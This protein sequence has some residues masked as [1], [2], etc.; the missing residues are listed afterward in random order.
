MRKVLMKKKIPYP[1][2]RVEW[3]DAV[4]NSC[5]FSVKE[6]E[7]WAKDMSICWCENIGWLVK[8]TKHYIVVA[9][10]STQLSSDTEAQ[11][12]NLQ[13]IPRT[14]CKITRLKV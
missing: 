6:M 13:K 11:F 5:R 9:S 2:V 7:E 10:R 3:I 14:W 8:K 4:S 12:G 1:L